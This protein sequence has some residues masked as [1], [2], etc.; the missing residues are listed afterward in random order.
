MSDGLFE[1]PADAYLIPPEP[2]QLSRSEKRHRLIAKRIAQGMHPLG[3][4]RLHP[5]ASK[6]RDG[7]GPR[8]GGCRFRVVTSY[9]DKTY[10]KCHFPTRRGDKTVHLRDTGCESS[11]IRA[12]WPACT[13]FEAATDA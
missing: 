11:D 12:W 10:P 4:V 13:D 3:Y 8:C 7:V 9:R 6:E 5:D 2:E 1:V